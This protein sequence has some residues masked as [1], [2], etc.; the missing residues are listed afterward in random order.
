MP[1]VCLQDLCNES[2][3]SLQ[4]PLLCQDVGK[5]RTGVVTLRGGFSQLDNLAVDVLRLVVLLFADVELGLSVSQ[6][7]LVWLLPDKL[8]ELRL[9]ELRSPLRS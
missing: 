7:I 2:L 6:L 9:G 3:R 4:I 5:P 8:E 1:W